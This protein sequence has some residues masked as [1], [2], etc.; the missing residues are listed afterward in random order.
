MK[1]IWFLMLM[2]CAVSVF[3]ACSDDD[4]ET[5]AVNPISNYSVPAEAEIG[6]EIT[7]KGTG[8]DASLA[9][10]SLRDENNEETVLTE[11]LSFT[12]SGVSFTIPMS[13]VAGDYTLFL[14]QNGVW[15]LGKIKLLP[16]AMPII[17]LSF[18]NRCIR[19]Q[20][21]AIAGNNFDAACKIYL[22]TTDDNAT[23]TELTITDR[24]NGVV[25]SVP[26]DVEKGIYNLVLAQS[27]TE[28]VLGEISIDTQ[29]RLKSMLVEIDF[30]MGTETNPYYLIYNIQ[31]QIESICMDEEGTMPWYNFTYSDGQ[32]V[33]EE[34]GGLYPF[35]LQLQDN[36]VVKHI[37][38]KTEYNW[39]YTDDKLTEIQTIKLFTM[40]SLEWKGDNVA[41]IEDDAEYVF[42]YDE[43]QTMKGIDI[44]KCLPY[45]VMGDEIEMI[46][47]YTELLGGL[48]GTQ[49]ISL[50]NSFT[51]YDMEIPLTCELDE[52][53]YLA[54]VSIQSLEIMGYTTYIT[55][56][57]E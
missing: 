34:V 9:K 19:G 12:T 40:V 54:S 45:L 36:K 35:T 17:G 30:G 25:C 57:Y 56:A 28:W 15:E 24:S 4:G 10:L 3:T 53:G 31:G 44:V 13:L 37:D 52:K 39:I 55:L 5:E 27:G 41:S 42:A 7:V 20:E 50:P 18:S 43:S 6:E 47:F 11:N 46:S 16:A 23:R 33:A 22:E 38:D 48:T 14:T 49:N 21:L 8:F 29:R 26:E 1:K 2:M 51:T 32:I